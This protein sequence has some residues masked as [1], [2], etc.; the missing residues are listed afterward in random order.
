[1]KCEYCHPQFVWSSFYL[2]FRPRQRIQ[3]LGAVG[4]GQSDITSYNGSMMQVWVGDA[5]HGLGPL[6]CSDSGLTSETMSPFRHF[7]RTPWTGDRPIASLLPTQDRT[8]QKNMEI[9]PCL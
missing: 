2:I 7:V 4:L 9:H 5:F 3:Y 8:T 1:M 6:A